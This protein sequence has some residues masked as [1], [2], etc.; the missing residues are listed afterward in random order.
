MAAHEE[1]RKGDGNDGRRWGRK[2]TDDRNWREYN[3]ELVV[4]GEFLLE[5]KWVGSWDNELTAMNN[6]KRGKPF[7]YPESL[8][9]L[10]GAW[11]QWIDYRGVEGVTRKMVE[12]NIVP[13]HNDFSTINRRVN[14]LDIGIALPRSGTVRVACDG[15]GMKLENGGEHRA[16]LYGKK[17]R[18]YIRVIITAD[19]T[20][21]QL[22]DCDVAVE[23]EGPS[24]PGFARRSMESMLQQ[25]LR[26]EK[27]WGDG[28]FDDTALF[29]FLER[30]GIEPAIKPR[31][32]A[33][34]S[35]EGTLRDR[36][37]TERNRLGYKEWARKRE[38]GQRWTGTEGIFSAV[39]RKFGECIRA[40][41]IENAIKKAKMKFWA[42][43]AMKAYA[44]T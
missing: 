9:K 6:G 14:A 34:L 19:P 37:I 35:G 8:I 13:T 38:Y 30:N 33:V 22:L 4:R 12:H 32:N 23:G 7:E 10:Q 42:Y 11:H 29:A 21:K 18:R 3:E 16:K 17:K 39:K 26:I 28:A 1:H 40:H 20:T 5:T 15:T 36:E 27:F 41:V 24:E 31:K 44:R 25:G 43:E 2:F